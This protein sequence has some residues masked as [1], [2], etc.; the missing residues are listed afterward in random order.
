MVRL[1]FSCFAFIAV[2][3]ASST[4][5]AQYK[6]S[7]FGFEAGYLAYGNSN[8]DEV[9]AVESHGPLVG[10]RTGWKLSD[11]FW[12]TNRAAFAW[13]DQIERVD[14]TIFILHLVPVAVRYYFLTDR[15]RPFLGAT[16]SFQFFMNGDAGTTFWG[17]G[18]SA[19]FEVRLR[20]DVFLGV[21]ADVFHMWGDGEFPVGAISLQLDLFL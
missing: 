8:N 21:Q 1:G 5:A 4:A 11:H 6:N 12:L 9:A 19:G 16:Q 13:R 20:R 3:V 10:V 18:A 2:V 7:Q 15:F 14:R 17:P